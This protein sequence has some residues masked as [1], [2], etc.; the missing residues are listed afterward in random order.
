MLTPAPYEGDDE[1]LKHLAG[2]HDQK[3]HGRWSSSGLPHELEDVRGSLQK[4]FEAG[5]IA[6]KDEITRLSRKFQRNPETGETEYVTVRVKGSDTLG[7]DY[8]YREPD[9]SVDPE[10]YA[11][12]KEAQKN[13]IGG[14]AEEIEIMARQEALDNGMGSRQALY[15]GQAILSRA[16]LYV[17]MENAIVMGEVVRK[18]YSRDVSDY[19][20]KE[21]KE[22]FDT[23]EK[24]I[25]TMGENISKSN[26]VVAIETE[27]FLNVI[28]DGR[29]KTQYETRESNGAYKPALRKEAELALSGIPLDTK[30]SERP[31]YGYL[32]VQNSGS[33]PNTSGYNSDR[34]NVNNSGVGQYGEVRVVLKDEVRE[35]TSYTALDSLDRYGIPQKLTATSKNDLIRS[36]VYQDLTA[37]HGGYQRESYTEAQIYGGV[38]ISDIKAV[39]VVPS[40]DY[41]W[42][43]NIYT[44]KDHIAQADS[45]RSALTSKGFDIPVEVLPLSKKKD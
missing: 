3:T 11:M 20:E 10:G 34:W 39:Y 38:K 42:D 27:D 44:P 33:T 17:N 9:E 19:R 26:P 16:S 8:F 18:I 6:K 28:K 45:I 37:S 21:L 40:S 41:N 36:G 15:Y 22:F 1:M 35:R 25:K 2:Q 31:I 29:F 5:L 24:T 23:Q 30:S 13:L 14:N 7:K 32:A 43:N 4:Y 12:F